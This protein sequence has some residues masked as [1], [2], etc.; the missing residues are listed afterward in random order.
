MG[1]PTSAIG[2]L[3]FVPVLEELIGRT[4]SSREGALHGGPGTRNAIAIDRMLRPAARRLPDALLAHIDGVVGT[5]VRV[6]AGKHACC[7]VTSHRNRE[8]PHDCG[9]VH[10]TSRG[11]AQRFEPSMWHCWHV[12][13]CAW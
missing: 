2:P 9:A 8:P 13:C 12:R 11:A 10:P 3:A 7:T 5:L 1:T 6:S 4:F